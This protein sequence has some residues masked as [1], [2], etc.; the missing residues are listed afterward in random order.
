MHEY[1]PPTGKLRT[2]RKHNISADEPYWDPLKQIVSCRIKL[3]QRAEVNHC[4]KGITHGG[5]SLSILN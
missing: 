2:T 5:G 4:F 1:V 3:M